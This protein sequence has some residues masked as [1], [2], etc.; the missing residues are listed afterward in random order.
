MGL[1]IATYISQL[2]KLAPLAGDQRKQGDD[3]LRLIKAVLKN[4][5]PGVGGQGFASPITAKETELNFL[6]GVTSNIQAQINALKV[7]LSAASG[8][9][10]IAYQ[11]A[12]PTGWTNL[13]LG[14]NYVLV[15]GTGGTSGGGGGV[16]HNIVTGCTV[17]ASHTH[18]VNPSSVTTSNHAGHSHLAGVATNIST[19]GGDFNIPFLSYSGDTNATSVAGA[20]THTVDIPSTTTSTNTSLDIWQPLYVTFIAINK[21]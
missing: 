15:S 5:F 10:L 2:D 11:A 12:A 20:H 3:H 7:A 19:P 21:T 6:A 13:G 4:T 1:E 18:T 8:T 9:R 16:S 14:A 17:V